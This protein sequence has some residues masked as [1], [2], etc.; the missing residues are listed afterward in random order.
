MS[1][2]SRFLLVRVDDRLLHGQVAL[3]WGRALRPEA[4]W[5]VDDDLAG[6][7]FAS[8]LY[9]AALPDER[10]TLAILDSAGFLDAVRSQSSLAM[11]ILLMRGLAQLRRLCERGFTPEEVNL[12]GLH[13]R[14]GAKR[15]LDY[16][17]LTSDDLALARQLQKRGIVLYAQELP[18]S[19]RVSLDELTTEEG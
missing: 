11:T 3:G 17:Y 12:G 14:E 4:F 13:H 18:S 2:V 6:D 10:S 8:R 1:A 5:I 15:F 16:L 7:P 9:E 19:R